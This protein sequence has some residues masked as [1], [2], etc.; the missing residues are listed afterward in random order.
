MKTLLSAQK[1]SKSVAGRSLFKDL[2]FG[3]QEGDRIGLIGPNGVGKSTL[4]RILTGREAPDSGVLH[5]SQGLRM[6]CLDQV[7]QFEGD[8]TLFD[9]LL[10]KCD[11]PWEAQTQAMVWELISKLGFKEAGFDESMPVSTLSGGWQK[12]AALGRELMTRPDL[13]FL[14]E[15]T[16]HLDVESIEWLEGY[17][18]TLSCATLTVTHD[19]YFLDEATNLIWELDPRNPAQLLAVR[20]GY[21]EYVTIRDELIHAQRRREQVLSNTLRREKEWLS[22]QAQARQTK[23]QARIKQAHQ[24]MDTVDDLGQR[25]TRREAKVEFKGIEGGTKRLIDAKGIS[26]AYD[27][28][29]VFAKLDVTVM[30]GNKL[31][32]LGR[33]GAG[34]STLLRSLLGHEQPDA[35]TI[36]RAEHLKVAFFEQRRESLDPLATVLKTLCPEGD[37]VK[38]AGNYVHVRSYMDRF[39][40]TDDFAKKRVEQLSGGEQARLLI[41]RLMLTEANLLVLDEPTNDLDIV[42]LNVLEES[43]REFPGALILVSHDRYF[44]EQ[45]CNQYLAI[46]DGQATL[47]ASLD[48]WQRLRAARELAPGK[49]SSGA[50]QAS[51]P[52]DAPKKKLSFK[53]QFE[54][55]HMEESVLKAEQEVARLSA[56][57]DYAALAQ[58]QTEVERLYARWSAL[59]ALKG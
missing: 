41:A 29:Q 30:A 6:A 10:Q 58:A 9:A 24:L 43:L 13:L 19:R 32:L 18:K 17:L 7:P 46:Q 33:N 1:L 51:K 48:Q 25:N 23:Q 45:V 5:V 57:K 22:R 37:Y 47:V 54:L 38:F 12:R 39:L 42:T 44:M 3:V 16:N 49:A 14:D 40:F 15:P 53:D 8:P 27:G 36:A 11:D 34:K 52:A 35:G 26:K 20:G 28:R 56:T 50:S 31:G 55:D 2:N 59:E 4:L 21:A